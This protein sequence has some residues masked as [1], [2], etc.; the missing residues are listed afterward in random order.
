[1]SDKLL[2]IIHLLLLILRITTDGF[3]FNLYYVELYDRYRRVRSTIHRCIS[4]YPHDD[5]YR[6]ALCK[7]DAILTSVI[8]DKRIKSLVKSLKD[9]WQIFKRLREILENEEKRSREVVE[10][11]MRRFLSSLVRKSKIS[12]KYAPLV[13]V[14]KKFWSGLFYTYDHD[15]IPQEKV[16]KNDWLYAC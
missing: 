8:A 2:L 9:D 4:E 12:R 5:A 14:I 10:G 3:P 13:K 11:R 15:C 6:D 16:E 1:V 7:L